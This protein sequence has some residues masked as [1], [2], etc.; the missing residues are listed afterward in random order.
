MYKK[1]PKNFLI[2]TQFS[3]DGYPSYRRRSL[4]DGSFETLVV[5]HEVDCMWTVSYSPLLLKTL[6][7]H[8]NVEFC[9]SVKY[10]CK[11]INKGTDAV[12]FSLQEENV[13][14]E[15]IQYE[16]GRYISTNVT[17]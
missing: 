7:A 4:E 8:I 9:N 5:K 3:E 2:Q 6:S 16:L 11:Y 13:R 14:D 10:D 12:M 15:V 17:F 1:Y